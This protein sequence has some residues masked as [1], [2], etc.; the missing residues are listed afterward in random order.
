MDSTQNKND[1]DRDK[2]RTRVSDTFRSASPTAS[3]KDESIPCVARKL[4]RACSH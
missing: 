3:V 2:S 1:R 4:A